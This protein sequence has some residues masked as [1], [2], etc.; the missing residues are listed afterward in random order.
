MIMNMIMKII[1]G[2]SKRRFLN[3]SKIQSL[4]GRGK[5]TRFFKENF[6]N[7]GWVGVKSP[8]LF[9][10]CHVYMAYLTI[11]SILFFKTGQFSGNS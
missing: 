4:K 10:G 5:K 1:Y 7:C 6:L 3:S 8:K 11:L 2:L 9:G